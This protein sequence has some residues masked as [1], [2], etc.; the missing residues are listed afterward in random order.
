MYKHI[1][2]T[3]FKDFSQFTYLAQGS[4]PFT[5]GVFGSNFT[6]PDIVGQLKPFPVATTDGSLPPQVSCPG[7][8]STKRDTP[9]SKARKGKRQVTSTSTSTAS[10]TPVQTPDTLTLI[11]DLATLDSKGKGQNTYNF[12]VQ[13]SQ[14]TPPLPA[15]VIFGTGMEGSL[16]PTPMFSLGGGLFE[17]IVQ[18]RDTGS[19][20]D[21]FTV[22]STLGGEIS[23][24]L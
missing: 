20:L 6:N 18:I 16:A 2:L 21:S 8:V 12:T 1:L 10:A 11:S 7:T 23:F 3:S 14:T 4:G 9:P 24:P 15:L 13:S 17:L 19:A 22:I 5:E